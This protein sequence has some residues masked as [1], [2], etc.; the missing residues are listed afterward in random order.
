MTYVHVVI[1]FL[2]LFPSVLFLVCSSICSQFYRWAIDRRPF[3]Q[4]D[5]V[6]AM[7]TF[8]SDGIHGRN[9]LLVA[10]GSAIGDHPSED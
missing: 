4:T 10:A 5:E 1:G 2:M 6:Y 8:G 7:A 9:T 3:G